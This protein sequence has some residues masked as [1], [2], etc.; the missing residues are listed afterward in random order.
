MRR[1]PYYLIYYINPATLLVTGVIPLAL[2]AYWNYIIYTKI[3][4]S[5]K[6]FVQNSTRGNRP[7][8]G[9]KQETEFAKVF[10]G[11]VV[12]FVFSHSLRIVLNFQEAISTKGALLCIE[13]KKEGVPFWVL[14]TNECNKLLLVINSAANIVIYCCMNSKFRKRL[15]RKRT[16]TLRTE[17]TEMYTEGV[18]RSNIDQILRPEELT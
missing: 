4:S 5:S 7:R 3:K 9:Q 14:I 8:N 11:I 1:N 17:N 13:Q 16:G 6:M 2:L 15:L 12:T 18:R 10:I